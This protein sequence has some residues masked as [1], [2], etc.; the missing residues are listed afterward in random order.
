MKSNRFAA[1]ALLLAGTLLGIPASAAQ[2]PATIGLSSPDFTTAYP[3]LSD[4]QVDSKAFI[5]KLVKPKASGD[6]VT[7][8]RP[9]TPCRLFD[10]RGFPA[11]IVVP[12][13]FAVNSTT[14]ITPAGACGIP[15]TAYTRGLSLAVSVQKISAG[16]GYIA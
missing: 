6:L 10:T 2:G 13:P 14:A 1:G 7:V 5:A 4:W 8:Y 16:G 12:G 3:P 15:N 9:L 11:A